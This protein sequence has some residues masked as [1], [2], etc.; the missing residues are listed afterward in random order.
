MQG[1][2]TLAMSVA[3]HGQRPLSHGRRAIVATGYRLG[4]GGTHIE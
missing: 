4:N 3:A 2:A 1:R